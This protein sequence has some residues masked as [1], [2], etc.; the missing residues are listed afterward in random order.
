M[1]NAID[2]GTTDR[3]VRL[4][5]YRHFLDTGT[6]PSVVETAR[7]L[8]APEDAI[9]SS[10]QRLADGHVI[11][12]RRGTGDILMAHPLSAVPTRFRVTLGERAYW[13]NCI[14]DALG[15]P[16]MLHSDARI[17]ALCGDC[18]GPLALEVDAGHLSGEGV[19]HFAVPALHWWDDI[20]YT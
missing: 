8:S 12:L 2:S 9:A 5:I 16:A 7:A 13:G 15:I 6:P 4:H 3:E 17:I 10:Y 11:V 18:D 20:E 19:V 14:W 1:T